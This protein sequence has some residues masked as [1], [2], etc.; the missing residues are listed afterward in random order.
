MEKVTTTRKQKLEVTDTGEKPPTQGN[1]T[2]HLKLGTI[3][4]NVYRLTIII[5]K[6]GGYGGRDEGKQKMNERTVPFL[7]TINNSTEL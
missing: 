4:G 3:L 2:Q 7:A 6:D 1:N 5:T